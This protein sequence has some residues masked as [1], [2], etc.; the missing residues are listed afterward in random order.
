[1]TDPIKGSVYKSGWQYGC[2]VALET[3]NNVSDMGT[4]KGKALDLVLSRKFD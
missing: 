4:L 1:M 3:F 2:V